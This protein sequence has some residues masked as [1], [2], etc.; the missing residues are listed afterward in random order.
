MTLS[1]GIDRS[2]AGPRGRDCSP[3]RRRVPLQSVLAIH[4]GQQVGGAIL[5]A[6]DLLGEHGAVEPAWGFRLDGP[7]EPPE[8]F[9]KREKPLF[10]E[11]ARRR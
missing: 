4:V 2:P 5:D 7:H 6:A 8:L 1:W 9:R 11:I 10:N 3:F